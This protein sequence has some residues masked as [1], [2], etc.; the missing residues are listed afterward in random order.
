[1]SEERERAMLS[2]IREMLA[3]D[4]STLAERYQISIENANDYCKTKGIAILDCV[5]DNLDD[6]IRQKNESA[7]YKGLAAEN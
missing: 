3:M 4:L 2:E 6:L 1:M 7:H 5:I